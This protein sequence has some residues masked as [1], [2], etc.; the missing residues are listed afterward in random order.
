MIIRVAP[1]ALRFIQSEVDW[2]ARRASVAKGEEVGD[3]LYDALVQV[4]QHYSTHVA[5]LPEVYRRQPIKPYHYLCYLREG[6]TAYVYLLRG[7]RQRPL[8]PQDH[9]ALATKAKRDNIELS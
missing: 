9:K 8:R 5:G 2:F 4:G 1:A 3:S 6:N 7:Q